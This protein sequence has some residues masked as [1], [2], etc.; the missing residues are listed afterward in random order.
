MNHS[1]QGQL[2]AQRTKEELHASLEIT[3]AYVAEIPA[4]SANSILQYAGSLASLVDQ[5]I[6]I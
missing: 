6:C 2:V 5:L 4:K 1:C 3:L